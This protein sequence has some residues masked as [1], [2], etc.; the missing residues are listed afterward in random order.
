MECV[1]NPAS[2]MRQV[3]IYFKSLDPQQLSDPGEQL[4]RVLDFKRHLE[5]QK[6][7]LY[8]TFDVVETFRDKLRRD[9]GRWLRDH[10]QGLPPVST[11][12]VV[13]PSTYLTAAPSP[14]DNVTGELLSAA[15]QLEQEGKRTDAE[16]TLARAIVRGADPAAFIQYGDFLVRDGRLAQAGTMYERAI[17]LS[18]R[19][20]A[21]QLALKALNAIG[22]VHLTS[23]DWRSAAAES[24]RSI[25]IAEQLQDLSSLAD[26]YGN[27][28]IALTNMRDLDGAEAMHRKSLEIEQKLGRRAG[29]A[30]DYTNLGRVYVDRGELELAEEMYQKAVAIN[31]EISETGNLALNYS[32]LALIQEQLGDHLGAEKMLLRA[33]ELARSSGNMTGEVSARLNLGSGL[34]DRGDLEA[35]REHCQF[36]LEGA[37]A[38]GNTDLLARSHFN[39]ALLDEKQQHWKEAIE[40]YSQALTLFQR[41]GHNE[42][43]NMAMEALHRL[44]SDHAE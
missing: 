37:R 32:N 27:L 33:I 36:A 38:L 14:V 40:H 26:A 7:H 25:V 31:T 35:A 28:G 18:E 8:I 43:A 16:A 12:G 3:L 42:H 44:Q 4:Q 2:P 1:R 23:G 6:D 30:A 9:L 13:E 41:M 19:I 24:R 22:R 17:E 21:P 10:D 29:M 15:A 11:V 39:L 5:E 20:K 34:A